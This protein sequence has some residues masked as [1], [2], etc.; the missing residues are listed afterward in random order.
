MFGRRVFHG[1]TNLRLRELGYTATRKKEPPDP[2]IQG[3]GL[4]NKR[5]SGS[6]TGK[7]K[8]Q[9]KKETPPVLVISKDLKEGVRF[10][11][12][13]GSFLGS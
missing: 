4:P 13:T 10:H 3:P 9:S 5:P 1:F 6:I 8:S 12:R 7:K 2:C 11:E